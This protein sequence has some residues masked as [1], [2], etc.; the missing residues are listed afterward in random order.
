LREEIL[1]RL[2]EGWSPEQIAGRLAHQAGDQVI[3]R[4]TI[5]RFVYAQLKQ[6]NERRWR[7]YLPR[8]KYK[9]GRRN[10]G[11]GWP[12]IA[13]RCSIHDRPR[14]IATRQVPGHW[15]VDGI[16]FSAPVKAFLNSLH[17]ECESTPGTS[18]G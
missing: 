17:F 11:G 15:E 13:D 12:R 4:E 8:S 18:P 5:Y 10:K 16:L 1:N 6:T 7:L 2:G 3:S 14:D 9:R